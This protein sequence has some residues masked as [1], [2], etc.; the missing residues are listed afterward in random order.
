MKKILLTAS[1][2]LLLAACQ[3]SL[4]EKCAREA[5]TY[6][7]KKCPAPIN[8]NTQID[9]LAFEA[10]THT[11]HYYYTLSGNADD[12]QLIEKVNP[13]QALLEEVKNATAM[14][15]YKEAGYNFSY[16]YRSKKNP[17]EILFETTITLKD[18][19]VGD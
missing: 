4:E 12:K 14:K 9:S 11:L 10:S 16:T 1:A 19:H 2:V 8:E 18:Y 17:N 13:R 15:L 3:E 5:K 7:E 6:T